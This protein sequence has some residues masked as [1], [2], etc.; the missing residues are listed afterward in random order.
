MTYK[1]WSAGPTP[2]P[3][4]SLDRP[5]WVDL[6]RLYGEPG[7]SLEIDGQLPAGLL[8]ATGRVPGLLKRW[9]RA[10]DGRWFGLVDFALCDAYGA[11][12]A[13]VERA[14]VPGAVLSIRE[15]EPR[16]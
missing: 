4:Q 2:P 3:P 8:V 7:K 14:P 12:Q 16:R 6:D 9:I 11:V 10:V 1:P 15:M 13:R 5:V